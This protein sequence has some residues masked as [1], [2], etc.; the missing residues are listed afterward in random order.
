MPSGWSVVGGP[1]RFPP[2]DE[3]MNE[4]GWQ[5]RIGIESNAFLLGSRKDTCR[6]G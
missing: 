4:R 3:S 1:V 2:R 6:E 5:T